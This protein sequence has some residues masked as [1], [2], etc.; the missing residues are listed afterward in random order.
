MSA[1]IL[2]ATEPGTTP[3]A[4]SAKGVSKTE[5]SSTE[6]PRP[7]PLVK[8]LDTT[9]SQKY[10][11]TTEICRQP[12]SVTLCGFCGLCGVEEVLG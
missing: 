1:L 9:E 6:V 4:W 5:R 11:R 2:A 8:C 7:S 10:H 12:F 3:K